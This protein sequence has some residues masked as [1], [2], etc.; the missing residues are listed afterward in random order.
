M[1]IGLGHLQLALVGNMRW[2]VVTEKLEHVDLKSSCKGLRRIESMSM[3]KIVSSLLFH[4]CKDSLYKKKKTKK[5]ITKNI[6]KIH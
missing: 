4:K 2:V 1:S 3:K 5:K 6:P